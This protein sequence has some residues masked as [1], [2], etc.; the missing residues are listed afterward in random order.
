MLNSV[1]FISGFYEADEQHG[2]TLGM[3]VS[4]SQ[5]VHW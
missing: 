1:H 2:P 4:F 5:S 3:S